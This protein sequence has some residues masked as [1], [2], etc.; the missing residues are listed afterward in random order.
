MLSDE[1]TLHALLAAS[2]AE[3]QGFHA[4]A[5]A[6]RELA[7][8]FMLDTLRSQPWID[9]RPWMAQHLLEVEQ[10]GKGHV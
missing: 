5:E 10:W 9:Q 4:T 6:F 7:R 8:T 1:M 2:T 3:R